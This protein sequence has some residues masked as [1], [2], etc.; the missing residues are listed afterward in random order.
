MTIA[1]RAADALIL[2]R[3]RTAFPGDAFLT[4][5][6]PDDPARFGKSRVWIID[7]L[8]GTRDFLAQTG[9]FSVHIGLCVDSQP[10]LGVVYQPVRQALYHARRGGGAFMESSGVQ[11]R[12]THLDPKRAERAA[13]RHLAPQPGRGARQVPGRLGTGPARGGDGG[14]GQAHGARA[15]RSRR[16]PQPLARRAGVGHLRA[17]GDLREAGCTVS[18]GDGNPMRYNQ[19]DLYRRRGSVASNGLCHPFMIRVMAPAFP[20]ESPSKDLS[21][22]I[23]RRRSETMPRGWGGSGDGSLV[24]NLTND[25][26]REHRLTDGVCA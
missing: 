11:S 18:D 6:S 15:R 19:K 10:V 8:D 5:E 25:S 2:D 14:V 3:L 9:D 20:E 16:G 12:I 17:G 22:K 1:D 23:R 13:G 24:S 4:E 21:A 7:P 26:Q